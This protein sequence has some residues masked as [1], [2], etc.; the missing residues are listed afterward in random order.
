MTCN[1]ATPDPVFLLLFHGRATP[2]EEYDGRGGFPSVYIGPVNVSFTYG[3]IK[4]HDAEWG[5]F[6]DLPEIDGCVWFDGVWYSDVEVQTEMNEDVPFL[7]P[8]K[9]YDYPTAEKA[10]EAYWGE[11][12]PA[13]EA[14]P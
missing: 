1:P 10:V 5:R 2:T 7:A 13:E 3:T 4:V 9:V 12:P 8:I 11:N 6:F 14:G